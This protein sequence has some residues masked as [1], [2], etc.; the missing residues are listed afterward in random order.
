[1]TNKST[2]PAR[3]VCGTD[4]YWRMMKKSGE[5]GFTI[6]DIH[7]ATNTV[8]E[9]AVRFYVAKLLDMGFVEQIGVRPHKRGHAQLYRVIK[10]LAKAPSLRSAGSAREYRRAYQQMWTAMRALPSFTLVELRAAAST[11]DC[12]IAYPT[13]QYYVMKLHRAG[14]LLCIA[15]STKGQRTFRLK[16]SSNSGPEPLIVQAA[17]GCIF[18]PNRNMRISLEARP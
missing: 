7:G 13:A 12:L 16:P 15:R 14:A 4:H 10:P 17:E 5:A 3:T 11:D 18:D 9:Q 1:M 2:D 6:R 8:R